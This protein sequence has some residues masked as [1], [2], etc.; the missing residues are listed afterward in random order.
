M[1]Y[2]IKC[3]ILFW[4]WIYFKKYTWDENKLRVRQL[5]QRLIKQQSNFP[6]RRRAISYPNL[7]FFPVC[8]KIARLR[9]RLF[10]LCNVVRDIQSWYAHTL[11]LGACFTM[12]INCLFYK[13][14]T[15]CCANRT[16]I[17]GMRNGRLLPASERRGPIKICVTL[18]CL[19]NY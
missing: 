4:Y 19:G 15:T 16:Q 11:D 7:A 3:C 2:V 14:N 10:S 17:S 6:E 12:A 18:F 13:S 5:K 1:R 8:T 9:C